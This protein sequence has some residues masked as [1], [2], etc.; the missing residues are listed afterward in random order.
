[1]LNKIKKQP[2]HIREI[3]MW[4]CVSVMFFVVGGIW[5]ASF[6]NNLTTM[7]NPETEKEVKTAQGSSPLSFIT[8]GFKNLKA[9]ISDLIGTIK[10]EDKKVE[11]SLPKVEPNK[12]PLSE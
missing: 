8:N 1:M 2:E 4:V 6:K 3:M 11:S 7:L 12:L 5:F 9:N 10:N